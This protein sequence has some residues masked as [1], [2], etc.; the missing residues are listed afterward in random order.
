MSDNEDI[1]LSIRTLHS[2]S[3]SYKWFV[4]TNNLI[5]NSSIMHL[6]KLIRHYLLYRMFDIKIKFNI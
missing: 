3:D 6:I 2:I 1:F 5:I 4:Y